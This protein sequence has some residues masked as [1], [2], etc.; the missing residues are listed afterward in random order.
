MQSLKPQTDTAFSNK[1]RH[2]PGHGKLR[3]AGRPRDLANEAAPDTFTALPVTATPLNVPKDRQFL[4]RSRSVRTSNSTSVDSS[5]ALRYHS[6]SFTAHLV[7]RNTCLDVSPLPLTAEAESTPALRLRPNSHV[8][9]TRND[10]AVNRT[11]QLTMRDSLSTP[12]H[13]LAVR[14]IYQLHALAVRH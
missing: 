12:R 10:F 9:T 1:T 14:Q 11:A 7:S 3:S 6:K 13:A 5:K 2:R 8:P 4:P